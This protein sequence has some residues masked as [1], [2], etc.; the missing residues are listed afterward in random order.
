MTVSRLSSHVRGATITAAM[1]R[2]FIVYGGASEDLWS[3]PD[4]GPYKINSTSEAEMFAAQLSEWLGVQI[5]RVVGRRPPAKGT[6]I[7]GGAAW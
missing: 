4:G 7:W 6:T 2:T 5:M 3:K 1:S